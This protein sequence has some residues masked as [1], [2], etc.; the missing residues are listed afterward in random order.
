[1]AKN[2]AKK[3][4]PL[5]TPEEKKTIRA[6]RKILKKLSAKWEK[7]EDAA[8]ANDQVDTAAEDRFLDEL[9]PDHIDILDGNAFIDIEN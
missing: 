2:T 7:L 4:K 9:E 1:M 5:L 8:W 6:A 3:K